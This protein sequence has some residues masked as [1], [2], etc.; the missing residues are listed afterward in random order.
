MKE[1]L[2][3]VAPKELIK[4]DISILRSYEK[5]DTTKAIEDILFMQSLEGRAHNGSGVFDKATFV[6][7]TIDD[8]VKALDCDPRVVKEMRQRLIDDI[9][10]FV[11]DTLNGQKRDRLITMRPLSMYS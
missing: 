3:R 5:L 8:I 10:R 7:T 2:S 6:N 1:F 4:Q 11:D 9:V